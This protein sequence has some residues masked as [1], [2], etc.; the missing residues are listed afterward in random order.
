[1]PVDEAKTVR[2]SVIVP[3]DIYQ[4]VQEL[5]AKNDVS[6]AWIAAA[7]GREEARTVETGL[8]SKRRQTS[9]GLRS[10]TRRT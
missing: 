5:A 7:S 3:A 6:A 4:W 8:Q 10:T 1:M 2:T 9:P